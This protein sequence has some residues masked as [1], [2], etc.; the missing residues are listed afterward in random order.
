M[1][2]RSDSAS[3]P[4]ADPPFF[5][6][7]EGLFYFNR[8]EVALLAGIPLAPQQ[9]RREQRQDFREAAAPPSR[10]QTVDS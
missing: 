1:R 5:F 6:L 2:S 8:K 4:A 7:A 10:P 3:V 9:T